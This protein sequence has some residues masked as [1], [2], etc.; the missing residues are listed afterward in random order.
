MTQVNEV[1]LK[2]KDLE[3]AL[4]QM[5]SRHSIP[6][7]VTDCLVNILKQHIT[8]SDIM[9]KVNLGRTKANYLIEHGLAKVYEKETEDL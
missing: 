4:V 9:K 2:A 3:I 6:V 7:A 5:L 8:D 1:S